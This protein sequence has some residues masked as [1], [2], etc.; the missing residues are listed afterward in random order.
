LAVVE[1]RMLRQVV[2]LATQ[3]FTERLREINWYR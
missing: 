3:A 2:G 1:R